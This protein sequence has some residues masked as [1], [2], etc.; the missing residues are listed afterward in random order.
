MWFKNLLLYRFTTPF[1]LTAEQ[2]EDQLD[3]HR[4]T[5]C[6]RHDKSRYGWVSPLSEK[7]TTLTHAANGCIML[8]A[9][10]EEKVLPAA[11]IRERLN[12][13]V[14]EI[15]AK[16]DRKVYGKEKEALKEDILH[17]CLP[18]AFTRSSRV[19]GYIAP[20]DGWLLIDA[21]SP[22][23]AEEFMKHLRESIGTLPVIP[24]QVK[25]SPAIVMTE[26]LKQASLPE[27]LVLTDE[28]ELREPGDG[29]SVVRCKNQ[30]LL[31]EEI[32]VHLNAG[33]QVV[34]LGLEWDEQI[35]LV[36]QEDLAVKRLKFDDKLVTE[37]E[38][39]SGGDKLAQFDA[40]FALMTATLKQFVPALLNYFG[41]ARPDP[42]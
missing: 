22:G 17:D 24:I 40:D 11:V 31:S 16:E 4:F 20:Q 30:D 15:E 5:P 28:C 23:K 33:K 18:Q 19:Y 38:E 39:A 7:H 21:S 3:E 35:K 42:I 6:G 36:L 32:D 27:G 13:K 9:R 8:C 14:S 10:K 37:S 41:D 2:L 29:G 26:W 12:D 25:A 1:E 34:K